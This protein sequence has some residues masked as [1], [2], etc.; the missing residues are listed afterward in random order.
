MIY[1][2]IIGNSENKSRKIW[3]LRENI[4]EQISKNI[5]ATPSKKACK[6]CEFR[7]TEHCSVGV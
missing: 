4:S 6:W 5:K 7:K 3:E 1:D 2:G